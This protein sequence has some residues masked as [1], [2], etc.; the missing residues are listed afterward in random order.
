M[1]CKACGQSID[2][3]DKFCRNCGV[4]LAQEP[5]EAA[6]AASAATKSSETPLVVATSTAELQRPLPIPK[7]KL[8]VSEAAAGASSASG[9]TA[10]A[11]GE[12]A[13][14]KPAPDSQPP[15]A[16]AVAP[17]KPEEQL[18]LAEVTAKLATEQ[19]ATPIAAVTQPAAEPPPS[20]A[21]VLAQPA[22]AAAKGENQEGAGAR[23]VRLC[24]Q[25]HR[26]VGDED[27]VCERC[28]AKLTPAA[29]TEPAPAPAGA[30]YGVPSFAGY[31]EK[32]EKSEPAS[33]SVKTQA[34]DP[35]GVDAISNLRLPRRRR[36]PV[37]EVLVALVLLAGAGV[38]VWMLHSG[39]PGKTSIAAGNVDVTISPT[40]AKVTAGHGYDL[41]A[42]VT[43]TDNYNVEWSVDEGD[44][45]GRI[46]PRGAKAK[47]GAVS[48]LAVYMAPKT[49][50]T[51]HVTATSKADPGKAASA[52]IT[53][54]K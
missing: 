26:L 47:D 37:V 44:G 8:A 46:V 41:A 42:T 32:A 10:D 49:P 54:T 1:F 2:R 14:A 27:L 48:S 13:P 6:V 53:V 28:K 22:P 16:E 15:A 7:N 11:A 19:Q 9:E 4:A 43:G 38:A 5:F 50:G 45:G 36:L 17:A 23:P 25:C 34:P 24:P 40:R 39:L 29:A 12:G 18:L 20:P 52:T 30:D 35:S 31:A 33:A 51:Y 3:G 21:E